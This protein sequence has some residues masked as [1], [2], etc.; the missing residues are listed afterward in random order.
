MS[1]CE[2]FTACL[3]T[4]PLVRLSHGGCTYKWTDH[5]QCQRT[6][7]KWRGGGEERFQRKQEL[8]DYLC[9]RS[10][11]TIS[12]LA[13]GASCLSYGILYA[14]SQKGLWEIYYSQSKVAL[15]DQ[16]SNFLTMVIFSVW[17]SQA[18]Q[19]VIIPSFNEMSTQSPT[20]PFL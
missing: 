15:H 7:V 9:Y 16:E 4:L 3:K 2:H 11:L 10:Q 20:L 18:S 14:F 19:T 1:W 6:A 5:G 17:R 12:S 8:V 13:R